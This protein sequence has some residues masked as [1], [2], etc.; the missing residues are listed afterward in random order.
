VEKPPKSIAIMWKH[1]GYTIIVVA[2]GLPTT[3]M[4]HLI[5]ERLKVNNK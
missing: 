1:I 5:I 3:T 4:I 2:C